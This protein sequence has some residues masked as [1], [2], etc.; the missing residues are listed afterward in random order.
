MNLYWNE[1]QVK[2]KKDSRWFSPRK[3]LLIN[4][5]SGCFCVLI[6]AVKHNVSFLLFRMTD[7]RKICSFERGM[8]HSTTL[9]R[10][11]SIRLSRNEP[12]RQ[13]FDSL[14]VSDSYGTTQATKL[15]VISILRLQPSDFVYFL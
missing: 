7:F 13:I 11:D 15:L 9:I 2:I 14:M 10:L 12:N 1:N 4:D 5:V 3:L 6:I 8:D